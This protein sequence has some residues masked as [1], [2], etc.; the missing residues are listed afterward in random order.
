M[1][2]I[3]DYANKVFCA[4]RGH[5]LGNK[6]DILQRVWGTYTTL[7]KLRPTSKIPKGRSGHS[8]PHRRVLLLSLFKN[9]QT[10]Q[11]TSLSQTVSVHLK[12]HRCWTRGLRRSDR[13]HE[14][15]HPHI[16]ALWS[17]VENRLWI[18]RITHFRKVLEAKRL[19]FPWFPGAPFLPH[20]ICGLLLCQAPGSS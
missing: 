18:S 13:R 11:P 2:S 9:G 16:L 15:L 19:H 12:L 7:P 17:L 14:L 6:Y 8:D 1:A 3:G 20:I 5:M 10:F 4:F